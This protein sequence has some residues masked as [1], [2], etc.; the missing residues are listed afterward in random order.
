MLKLQDLG[1]G[2]RKT[3]LAMIM[4]SLLLVALGG[5]MQL[6]WPDTSSGAFVLVSVGY[7]YWVKRR[8]WGVASKIDKATEDLSKKVPNDVT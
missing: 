6:I 3:L 2:P 4:I 7:M 1:L 8:G 5:V